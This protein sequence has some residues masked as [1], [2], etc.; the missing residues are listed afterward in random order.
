MAIDL[1][2]AANLSTVLLVIPG[3]YCAYA[4]WEGLHPAVAG[5][6]QVTAVT[7]V[8]P[9]AVLLAIGALV[10]LS[11]LA[12]GLRFVPSRSSS[13]TPFTPTRLRLQFAKGHSPTAIDEENIWRWYVV[14]HIRMPTGQAEA[15]TIM[16]VFDK[17]TSF[18]QIKLDAV[19]HL[20]IHEVKD[21][22]ERHLLVAF[23]GPL[24]G[25]VLD[26]YLV[27]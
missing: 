13:A 9:T 10:G 14:T 4:A 18:R 20:P 16:V 2:K 21:R 3:C 15:N 7:L 6:D 27:A 12:V 19:A 24:D 8:N 17:Q 1:Q 22:S 11:V 26:L 23:L 5:S 25:V